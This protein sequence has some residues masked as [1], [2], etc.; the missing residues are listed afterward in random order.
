MGLTGF[1]PPFPFWFPFCH[2]TVYIHIVLAGVVGGGGVGA[3]E[4]N[5]YVHRKLKLLFTYNLLLRTAG[6]VG[7]G[8]VGADLWGGLGSET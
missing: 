5:Y 4:G 6:F 8:C 2:S 7:G 1:P 3:P